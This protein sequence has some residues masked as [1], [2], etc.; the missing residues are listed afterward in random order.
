MIEADKGDDP[1]HGLGAKQTGMRYGLAEN[2]QEVMSS[3]SA[4]A[5]HMEKLKIRMQKAAANLEFEEAANIRD[6]IKNL[7][8]AELGL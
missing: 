3:Q 8:A 5:K 2:A 4:I 1:I 6:Q 7:E